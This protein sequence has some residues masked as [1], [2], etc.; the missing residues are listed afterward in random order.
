MEDTKTVR[1][2][3]E[4]VGQAWYAGLETFKA[5]LFA[6]TRTSKVHIVQTRLVDPETGEETDVLLRLNEKQM[7]ALENRIANNIAYDLGGEFGLPVEGGAHFHG[8]LPAVQE[9]RGRTASGN[10]IGPKTDDTEDAPE[11][12]EVIAQES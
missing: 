3:R 6:A 9:G 2:S 11:V 5:K 8:F 4:E 7:E 12:L 10:P 1:R